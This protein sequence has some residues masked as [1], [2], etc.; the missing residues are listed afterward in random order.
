MSENYPGTRC[1][2]LYARKH[3]LPIIDIFNPDGSLNE[4][5]AMYAGMDRFAVREKIVEDLQ[6]AGLLGKIEPYI[7]KVGF[8]ERTNVPIEP[9]LYAMVS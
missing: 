3:Q 6:K 8:S 5:G 2:R 4:N 1:Q 7:H 9:K